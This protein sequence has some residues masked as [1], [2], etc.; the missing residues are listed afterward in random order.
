MVRSKEMGF[1]AQ[2]WKM[3]CAGVCGKPLPLY[4]SLAQ[5]GEQ[6]QAQ[7]VQACWLTGGYA[8]QGWPM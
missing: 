5:V 2:V 3:H 1:E 8:E 6:R 4:T 7:R